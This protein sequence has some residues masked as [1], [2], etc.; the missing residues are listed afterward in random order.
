MALIGK[1]LLS[2]SPWPWLWSQ[3]AREYCVRCEHVNTIYGLMSVSMSLPI[4]YD[5]SWLF[6]LQFTL[7]LSYLILSSLAAQ[8]DHPL[9]LRLQQGD[10]WRH[11]A[12]SEESEEAGQPGPELVP[13]DHG[14]GPGVHRL[15]PHTPWA[16]HT[17]QVRGYFLLY[18]VHV[19][20]KGENRES[21]RFLGGS[22]TKI[23]KIKNKVLPKRAEE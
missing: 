18:H 8:P 6:S 11:R 16:A 13:E 7:V 5:L 3:K 10:G 2:N 22:L 15:R 17:G 23:D 19:I 1:S 20:L 21:P 14:R 9:A 4:S 12:D